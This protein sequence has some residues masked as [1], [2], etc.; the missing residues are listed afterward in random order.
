MTIP[1]SFLDELRART[2]LST[3]VQRTVP[4]KKAGR[5]WK[6]LCPVHAEK[7]PSFTVNDEKGF[8]HCFGCGFHADAIRW[9]TDIVGMSFIDAVK[10][11]AAAAG[12]EVPAP[13]PRAAEKAQRRDDSTAIMDKAAGWFHEQ[14]VG[15]AALAGR[16][17][18]EALSYLHR[19]DITDDLIA[20]F[21]IGF[22]PASRMGD[23]PH[24]IARGL[25]AEPLA[26]L[27]LVKRNA[28]TGSTYDFFRRR[29]MIPIHDARG[30][31]IA[32]GGRI[33][34]A[35]EPKYLNSPDTPV[36]DKGRTLFNLH[37]A[38]PKARA[39]GRLVV[40]EGYFD[41][42]GLARAGIEESVAPNG[43]ALTEAQLALCWK[44]VD[45]PIVCMDGDKAGRKAAVRAAIRSLPV[46]APGK[47][48]RFVF[49]EAGQDPDDVARAGGAVAVEAMLGAQHGIV[50]VLWQEALEQIGDRSPER[51][52]RVRRDLRDLVGTIRDPDVRSAYG[53]ELHQRLER[54][55]A[56]QASLPG[57]SAPARQA[58]NT[59]VQDALIK[60]VVASPAVLG[61][62][63]PQLL[64]TPW[65]N[66][67]YPKLLDG[68]MCILEDAPGQA[69]DIEAG[70]QRYA[71][72]DIAAQVRAL[73]TLR[74]PFLAATDPAEA[75]ALLADALR[76]TFSPRR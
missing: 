44:L 21:Q 71:C 65:H 36:F 10:E 56:R 26:E 17:A 51:L 12:M 16:D 68:L 58:V 13:D 2:T 43:T 62:F 70:L 74:F 5:E 15:G 46:L 69:L 8:G 52:S 73:P 37:R 3:L 40:V 33:V 72:T 67:D 19:R 7:S 4:L 61:T 18:G 28:D 47:G 29:I 75:E 53:S 42:I 55:G 48:L 24:L 20:A 6:G 9:M 60:G 63:G 23:T 22:A 59:A 25:P 50:D 38:A 76:A 64:A 35:G 57:R 39:T 41:V 27:G 11:L 31:T 1:A 49:P 32:F 54:L 30:K 34:G 14:L 45:E 66:P